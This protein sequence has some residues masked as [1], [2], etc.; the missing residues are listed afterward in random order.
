MAASVN[1][2]ELNQLLDAVLDGELA[3][4]EAEITVTGWLNRH[5]EQAEA[6]LAYVQSYHQQHPLPD[7]AFECFT[8]ALEN[9]IQ[10]REV[11]NDDDITRL[12]EQPENLKALLLNNNPDQLKTLFGGDSTH[13]DLNTITRERATHTQT[14]PNSQLTDS[15]SVK[16]GDPTTLISDTNL[17]RHSVNLERGMVGP[18][19]TLKDRF[20]LIRSIGEGGMGVVYKAKDLL[21][22]EAHDRNPYVAIKVLSRAFRSHQNAFISLQRE[23]SKAQRLAHPNIGT[24]YDFDREDDTIYMTMELLEGTELKDYIKQLPVDGL[25]FTEAFPLIEGMSNALAYAHQN[26]L[27]HS[28]FKPG[29]VF[30]TKDDHIKVI[31][32]GIARA[33][34]TR[35]A[36]GEQTVFDPGQLGALTPAYATQEMFEGQNPH[37]SDDVYA[38][39]CTSY[40]LLT[41]K[42]PYGKLSAPKAKEKNLK[43]FRIENK[44]LT[45]RQK[46]TL[47]RAV[48]INR[49]DRIQS[50]DEFIEGIRPH[51]SF[52]MPIAAA[53]ALI[54]ILLGWVGSLTVNNY[55]DNQLLMALQAEDDLTVQK[56]LNELLAMPSGKSQLAIAQ[57][58]RDSIMRYFETRIDNA[59]DPLN[60]K[61]DYPTAEKLLAQANRLY[62]DS[63][64]IASQ[65]SS[66]TTSKNLL[67]HELSERL[68]R[69][70]NQIQLLPDTNADNIPKILDMLQQIAPQHPLRNDERISLAYAK[71]TEQTL[72]ANLPE[73]AN[74]LLQMGLK[75]FPNNGRLQNLAD[76]T[77][78]ETRKNTVANNIVDLE[79]TL[80]PQLATFSTLKT[81]QALAD[82]VF[83]L[84]QL[85]PQ[86]DLLARIDAQIEPVFKTTLNEFIKQKNWSSA[87][88]LFNDNALLLSPLFLNAH[89]QQLTQAGSSDNP[90]ANSLQTQLY[91]QLA[92]ADIKD[93]SWHQK[94][95]VAHH[96]L[97]ATLPFQSAAI[98]KINADIAATYIT[99]AKKITNQHRHFLAHEILRSGTLFLTA[100]NSLQ[101]ADEDIRQIQIAYQAE[102]ANRERLAKIAAAKQSLL[103]QAEAEKIDKAL[104]TY[105][106]LKKELPQN[107]KFLTEAAPQA[108][109]NVFLITAN[110]A[111]NEKRINE[112]ESILTRGLAT[113]PDNAALKTAKANLKAQLIIA[114]LTDLFDT[115]SILTLDTIREKIAFLTRTTPER[116]DALN[117]EFSERLARRIKTL[118]ATNLR[119]AHALRQQGLQLWPENKALQKVV[120]PP[121]PKPSIF[122]ADGINK[123]ENGFITEAKS[124]L[125]QAEVK[126]PRHPDIMQLK[127]LLQQKTTQAQASAQ[128]ARRALQNFDYARASVAINNAVDMWKDHTEFKDLKKRID[129]FM[130]KIAAGARLCSD[131]MMSYGQDD[132]AGCYD[133]LSNNTRALQLVVIPPFAIG[134]PA[135]A[136]S[137]Y[138]ISNAELDLFCEASGQCKV[139]DNATQPATQVTPQIA[140]AYANWLSEETGF[141]YRLPTV[142]EWQHAA[143]A[144]GREANS[145]YNC[146]LRA[147][148]QLIKRPALLNTSFGKANRWGVVNYV[149]NAQELAGSGN[150]WQTLGGHY[151]DTMSNCNT[152]LSRNYSGPNA[153]TGFRLIREL[154]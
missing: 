8:R 106:Q 138:E 1:I 25:S 40:E 17:R 142:S 13:F 141:T 117:Q 7:A 154:N 22:V 126:E 98:Q 102:L 73:R 2:K 66:L 18:G 134:Q 107:D 93:Y 111:I 53:A 125:R 31:D 52:I 81:A 72:A 103:I 99:I 46:K 70:L 49:Q 87:E 116:I 36:E 21:K 91:K 59:V 80:Q 23:A 121:L 144:G 33:S 109:I 50:I 140:Q 35:N 12:L 62:A 143:N 82:A 74:N 69:A 100:Q 57:T 145:D 131:R 11:A 63:S 92:F 96:Q 139:G 28:D 15:G 108:L 76:Q 119:A 27:I 29:N 97:T 127:T 147:G 24:V 86:H 56:A 112:A 128:E 152:Q 37:P 123:A 47:L 115:A 26:S 137:K 58:S 104:T 51:P 133:L 19:S 135:Y 67:L 118:E 39:G 43:P 101:K 16:A 10:R 68:D 114:D 148:K 149:G 85:A 90:L 54:I 48:A 153:L 94:I 32:F 83:A 88:K 77:N 89:R 42:H 5:P 14:Q 146:K 6:Y 84:R 122:A 124:L 113:F 136:M 44:K 9:T 110:R 55:L 105:Q 60:N 4:E 78:I 150:S 61:Y 38:L 20:V 75:Y 41:G 34:T 71:A 64:V 65:Q 95:V 151:Q 129:T 3:L 132:R 45:S 120:L 79:K 30:L 130:Q